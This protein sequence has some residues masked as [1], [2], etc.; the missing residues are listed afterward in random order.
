MDNSEYESEQ[1]QE[2]KYP[3]VDITAATRR[4][5][6]Q[7]EALNGTRG[8]RQ[9]DTTSDRN[10]KNNLVLS[11]R[12][13][14]TS[15]TTSDDAILTSVYN[16]VT[17]NR[18]DNMNKKQLQFVENL[19]SRYRDYINSNKTLGTFNSKE[20]YL[21]KNIHSYDTDIDKQNIEELNDILEQQ[22]QYQDE[23]TQDYNQDHNIQAV[24]GQD[25]EEVYSSDIEEEYN[26]DN[27]AAFSAK[28][29]P[30][31]Q[32][33]RHYQHTD[34]NKK[35]KK[36]KKGTTTS[37]NDTA[38]R[39]A[40]QPAPQLEKY[41]RQEPTDKDLLTGYAIFMKNDRINHTFTENDIIRLEDLFRL[42]I[43]S[44]ENI[45]DRSK[46]ASAIA[47]I[48][49]KIDAI[50]R[51][52]PY[53]PQ[54][55]ID[56]GERLYAK[57]LK[58]DNITKSERPKIIQRINERYHN[59][60]ESYNREIYRNHLDAVRTIN[61]QQQPVV[62]QYVPKTNEQLVDQF[63]DSSNATTQRGT[64]TR[65]NTPEEDARLRMILQMILQNS[66]NRTSLTTRGVTN[67]QI[68]DKIGNLGRTPEQAV[69]K[70]KKRQ[71]DATVKSEALQ[72]AQGTRL[73]QPTTTKKS[74]TTQPKQ[75]TP[76]YN[77]R[78]EQIQSIQRN[79][80][81][82]STNDT[83]TY[84]TSNTVKMDEIKHNNALSK[85]EL[86]QAKEQLRTEINRS[87]AHLDFVDRYGGIERYINDM[88]PQLQ[89][90]VSIDDILGQ[91][92]DEYHQF[93]LNTQGRIKESEYIDRD[94]LRDITGYS[95]YNYD[96][97]LQ[98]LEDTLDTNQSSR[99]NRTDDQQ[100]MPDQGG[101]PISGSTGGNTNGIY[102]NDGDALNDYNVNGTRHDPYN[103]YGGGYRGGGNGG[104]GGGGGGGRGNNNDNR[105]LN[106]MARLHRLS[107]HIA[108]MIS[109]PSTRSLIIKRD[110]SI[111]DIYPE[112][113]PNNLN[114]VQQA[115][116][117]YNY[118]SNLLN[119]YFS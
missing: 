61:I 47:T 74:T 16:Y 12:T 28:P 106:A 1:Q 70:A 71:T 2:S 52:T 11:G 115:I 59:D 84:P 39:G 51:D 67:Q 53:N 73:R 9:V 14:Q 10:D 46:R 88:I 15:S 34:Q 76:N 75:G 21:L 97:L 68:K 91:S 62:Q 31:Q 86:D 13:S 103:P 99:D 35:G 29:A 114:I 44:A 72:V 54:E 101:L 90:G 87:G 56:E 85:F 49:D 79:D 69:T 98:T 23:A 96:E 37:A 89:E 116:A 108:N 50:P 100:D 83:K 8:V 82:Q 95:D 58:G 105:I 112:I 57:F 102:P 38:L 40:L 94:A 48:Q 7:A 81:N 113:K 20:V 60:V 111:K 119:V 36:G 110:T 18:T 25:I 3:D 64:K 80:T 42:D 27:A 6:Q 33:L 30:S 107:P 78:E 32:D 26:S 118:D 24:L 5:Q 63:V 109:D 93:L 92:I 117:R 65:L 55:Q 43:V 66:D 4:N 41:K 19:K 104:G 22:Q 17:K 45:K 77:P